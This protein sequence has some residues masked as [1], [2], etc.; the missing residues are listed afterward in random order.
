MNGSTRHIVRVVLITCGL[1]VLAAAVMAQASQT[2]LGAPPP[3]S[4][5]VSPTHPV[6]SNWY[7][8]RNPAFAWRGVTATPTIAG[9]SYILDQNALTVPDTVVDL[10]PFSFAPK[11]D[12]R[13][14]VYPRALAVG[15]FNRDGRLDLAVLSGDSRSFVTILL[16]KGNGTF[17]RRLTFR[18][19]NY[20]PM[21]TADLNRDGK[22]D[23]VI[24]NGARFSVFLGN[25]NG[26]FGAARSYTVGAD[27]AGLAIGDVN[28]DHRP[29]IVCADGDQVSV[30]LGRGDGTFGAAHA[31]VADPYAWDPALALADLNGDGRR[32]IVAYGYEGANRPVGALSVL[33]GKGIGGFK[34][35]VTTLTGEFLPE[36]LAVTDVNHDGKRDLLVAGYVDG[37][38]YGDPAYYAVAVFLGNGDGGFSPGA[39]YVFGPQSQYQPSAFNVADFNRDGNA[40]VLVGTQVGLYVLLGNGD[41]TFQAPVEFGGGVGAGL[42]G[43]FN[44]DGK[45]DVAGVNSQGDTVSVYLN[46]GTSATYS[47]LADGVWYFH[48][49]AV[50][51]G[52]VGGPTATRAVRIDTQRPCTLAPSA[53]SVQ[54]GGRALLTYGVNDPPPCAGWCAV[55][56]TLVD[57]HGVVVHRHA[58]GRV[59]NGVLHQT[60]FTC[61]L[62]KGLYRFFV[63]ATD[64][65]GNTQGNVAA[66]VLVVH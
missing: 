64:A 37:A 36:G 23:L 24:G 61:S 6:A 39:Q 53:A 58:S 4:G 66:N 21:A 26:T 2:A 5:L 9:Y 54:R 28:G 45:P 55:R 40:D 44:R 34:A 19:P 60:A 16:G 12:A 47:G 48:V 30:L 41:G 31:F 63:Y 57:S 20:S 46:R 62:P 56:I 8:N 29:D 42:V 51:S 33:L 11:L 32:D 27:A 59:H 25:G 50:D 14:P 65:A 1:A 49:R 13:I 18:A 22:L 17:G 43:D 15:D 38:D 10:P 3:L 7:S 35:A 52:A